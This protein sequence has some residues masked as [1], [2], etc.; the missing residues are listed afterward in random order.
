MCVRFNK[1]SSIVKRCSLSIVLIGSFVLGTTVSVNAY[2]EDHGSDHGGHS[3][4][5][6]H[7]GGAGHDRGQHGRGRQGNYDPGRERG[8]GGGAK[9]VENAVLRSGGRP[10]WAQ[11]GI[12][13]VELG[14]LNVARVPSHVLQRALEK[15]HAELLAN[16][17]AEIHA[18]MQ[19]IALYKEAVILNQLQKAAVYLGSAAEKRVPINADMVEA[20][21]IIL[22]V[23]VPDNSEM[24]NKADQVRQ[25]ILE[26]HDAGDVDSGHH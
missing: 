23:S 15:A 4:G 5:S 18:P 21:N 10:I 20:L 2:A 25:A 8:H 11:E 3:S 24:A 13:E 9:A 1:K 16:P 19:N 26:A 7:S 14:R 12:P 17:T 6:G 22:G